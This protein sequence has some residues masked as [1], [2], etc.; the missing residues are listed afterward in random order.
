MTKFNVF[1]GN[2]NEGAGTFLHFHFELNEGVVLR[3]IGALNRS[4]VEIIPLGHTRRHG[5]LSLNREFSLYVNLCIHSERFS[6]SSYLC[7][8]KYFNVT[9][10]YTNLFFTIG[11]GIFL[12]VKFCQQSTQHSVFVLDPFSIEYCK[13]KTS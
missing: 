12:F 4:V 7:A 2:T 1:W 13:T 5:G 8:F 10:V 6:K 9:I 11:A 3:P